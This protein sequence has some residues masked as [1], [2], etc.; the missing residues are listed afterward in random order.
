MSMRSNRTSRSLTFISTLL[1]TT[2]LAAPAFAQIEEIVVTAQKKSE[3][4]Q[5]V[6]IAVTAYTSEDLKAHQITKFDDLQFATPNV[7]YSQANFGGANFQ[8]RGLGVTAVGGGSESGVAVNFSDVFLAAPPTDG[9]S[10]YDLQDIEVLRGPQSTLYGRGATGGVV[11]IAPNRPDL[12]T[13]S[14][15]IDGQYGNYNGYEVKGDVNMPLITDQLGVRVAGDVIYHSGFTENIAD[16]SHQNDRSQYSIRGSV[17]W[18]PTSRT[19]VDFVG[20]FSKEDDQRARADKE[21]CAPDTTGVLGCTP[22]AP[23]TGALN[24]NATYLSIFASKDAAAGTFGPTFGLESLTTGIA[25]LGTTGLATNPAFTGIPGASAALGGFLGAATTG[26]N[27]PALLA[28][29]PTNTPANAAIATAIKTS[30]GGGFG[31]GQ[32]LGGALGLTSLTAPFTNTPYAAPANSNPSNVRQVNDDF[33]PINRQQDNFMSLEVK[34]NVTDWLDATAVGGYDHSSYFNQQSYTNTFGPPLNPAS[35]PNNLATAEATFLGLVVPTRTADY[36]PF[37]QV[38]GELP[39]SNFKNLG[40]SS[41]NVN[42]Y[43]SNLSSNDQASG[44]NSEI[45]G[46]LRFNSKFEGPIN[47]MIGG[48]Y[49]EQKVNE[50]YFVGSNSL[51]Y[52]GILL[53]GVTSGLVGPA[54]P[55]FLTSPSFY[56]DEERNVDLTSRSVF[57]EVYYD[58]LPDLLKLTLGA[59]YN[60]DEKSEDTRIAVLGGPLPIGSSD[61]DAGYTAAGIPFNHNDGK[62]DS[63]TGRA[64]LDYTPKLDFTDQTLFYASYSHGYKAGG[65]NP[66]IQAGAGLGLSDTYG[67]EKIDA[68]ELGTKNILL[69]G[70]LQAN[71]DVWYYNY[72]GL[73]VSSIIDNTSINE[74][75]AA[76]LYGVEG[77]FVWLPTDNLQ[78]NLNIAPTH[79]GV[80][81][82]SEID[83][84]NPTGGDPRA[85]L[86]KD[87][88]LTPSGNQ[89]CVI[90]DLNPGHA[91][92]QLPTGYTLVPSPTGGYAQAQFVAPPGQ[93]INALAGQGIAAAAY[94]SCSPSTQ[95]ATFLASQGYAETDPAYKGSSFTGVPEKLNGN[96][97]Q[98]TPNLN[99]S[100]GAQYTFNLDSGFTL[101]PRVDYYWQGHTWGRIFH[102]PADFIKAWDVVNGQITLNAPDKD[103]YVGAFIKNAFDKTYVT[104]EYLTSSSSGLYTNA[105]LGDPRT[106]G[107]TAGVKF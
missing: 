90:Y 98:Q 75:I 73:Q 3:D 93:P 100:I 51:D 59:R 101:V 25:A 62:F 23:Q 27:V 21:L 19:T 58:I 1:L 26:G 64:V 30:Y 12:E 77:E 2:A 54:A 42:R 7:T 50:D 74:N 66:G 67:P 49:L 11:N 47:F 5:T 9:A 88:T 17:R 28:A 4:I 105:F 16:G 91:T 106:Y 33:N 52:A 80:S 92:P 96:E 39:V 41:G 78:F 53:G 102:D 104:G 94:G 43:S 57:G 45:S 40:I 15:Q 44:N 65:F 81:N 83:E 24:L 72:Q 37:F 34:Q 95:L 8:I 103:W 36:A 68:Y 38:P 99:I 89:N 13:F 32:F 35:N 56:D 60:E 48:Y 61:Q 76:K 46:E 29:L 55:S 79:S 20:Q 107:V 85:I 84:R 70:N 69:G 18:E 14:T 31:I 82:T 10:F 71:A 63:T 87:D 86:V 22:A 6:P 97:L